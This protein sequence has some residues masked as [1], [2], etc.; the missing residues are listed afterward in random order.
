V[1]RLINE[2]A[3]YIA[4]T[5]VGANLLHALVH[6]LLAKLMRMRL[7]E[8][9]VFYFGRTHH[10]IGNGVLRVGW[11]PMGSYV[12]P[13]GLPIDEE[14]D[15]AL[16]QTPPQPYEYR[17]RPLWQRVIFS[18]SGLGSMAIG[19]LICIKLANSQQ[20]FIAN[21]Y[22]WWSEVCLFLEYLAW[23]TP[24][25]PFLDA[26]YNIGSR[27]LLFYTGASWLSLLLLFAMLPTGVVGR[28]IWRFLGIYKSKFGAVLTLLILI[29]SFFVWAYMILMMFYM[30]IKVYNLGYLILFLVNFLATSC[31]CALVVRWIATKLGKNA[32]L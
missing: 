7:D 24:P 1:Y 11:L 3:I 14:M 12:A 2:P 6:G 26:L 32:V 17:S 19:V 27:S 25:Q 13:A 28:A 31:A 15:A 16:A 23:K 5:L 20:S 4:L 18:L 8:V 9:S 10:P 22:D 29:L 30:L 21:L